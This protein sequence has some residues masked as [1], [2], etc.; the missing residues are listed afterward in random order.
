MKK[1][2]FI[3]LRHMLDAIS[4]IEE[5][6]HG[7]KLETFMKNYLI[8]DGVIRQ[9][10]CSGLA[11]CREKAHIIK[12][13]THAWLAFKAI[14]RIDLTPF[15]SVTSRRDPAGK[16]ILSDT[17]DSL[18]TW[19]VRLCSAYINRFYRMLFILIPLRGF[20]KGS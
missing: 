19:L 15:P 8:Q 13:Y 7:I 2:D 6:I 17:K 11:C 5:Y 12:K 4:R 3:Y 20:M 1:Y 9:V 10:L 16:G 14:D 18:G